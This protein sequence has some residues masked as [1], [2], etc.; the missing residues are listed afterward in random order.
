MHVAR[1]EVA[2]SNQVGE[3]SQHTIATV[4]SALKATRA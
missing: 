2:E 1:L 4:A 3:M